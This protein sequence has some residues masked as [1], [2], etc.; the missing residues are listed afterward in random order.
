M[1]KKESIVKLVVSLLACYGAGF[2]GSVFTRPAIPTWYA[3]LNKPSFNPPNWVFFPVWTALFTLMAIAAFL[4]WRKGLEEK[5]IPAALAFFLAQLI[6]NAFWSVAFFGFQSPIS[7]LVVI[8]I[9]WVAILLT[10]IWFFRISAAAGAL[11]LPYLCWVSF[12]A[13]LNLYIYRLNP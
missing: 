8:A 4:V 3:T 7:G 9:L 5:N 6:L 12:A 13:V 11:L 1:K 2:I 10:V